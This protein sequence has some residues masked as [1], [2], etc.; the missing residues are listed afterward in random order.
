MHKEGDEIHVDTDEVRGG[1]SSGVMRWVLLI[2]LLVAIVL[3]S[4][5]WMNGA[6]N[7]AND[8]P[9]GDIS[10]QVDPTD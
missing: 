2:G 6:A 4:I 8:E 5:V 7:S 9:I 1:S 10:G 3:L